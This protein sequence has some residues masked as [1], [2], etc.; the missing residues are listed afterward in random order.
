MITNVR[1]TNGQDAAVWIKEAIA[2]YYARPKDNLAYRSPAARTLRQLDDRFS[3][4]KPDTVVV[5]L[6]CF[7]GGWSQVA[8]ERAHA[9]S[10][11]SLVIGVDT[12]RMDPL[13]DHTF[14]QGDAGSDE[15]LERLLA[16][17]GGRRADVLLSDMAAPSTGLAYEDHLASMQCCLHAAKIMESTLRR[18][19]WFFGKLS[20]G[21]EKQ[22]W[23]TYLESRFQTVRSIKPPASRP[24]HREMLMA[25]RGYLGRHSIA[26]EVQ[27]AHL[28]L[29]KHEGMP[30]WGTERQQHGSAGRGTG[31]GPAA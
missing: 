14:I 28:D 23:R 15:T 21:A 30:Y 20:W 13:S 9:A 8:V 16:A 11:S 19:G 5:D 27:R 1:P 12:V 24:I 3:F 6:G 7:P 10:S 2:E 26:E 17:L 29:V 22:N 18:G 25:C 31:T 4:L